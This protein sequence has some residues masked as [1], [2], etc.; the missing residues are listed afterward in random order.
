MTADACIAELERLRASCGRADAAEWRDYLLGISNPVFD[1]FPERLPP[2]TGGVT[3]KPSPESASF[4]HESLRPNDP[5]NG[6]LGDAFPCES[7]TQK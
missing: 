7:H 4:A 2:A 6:S 5:E 3:A 1:Q